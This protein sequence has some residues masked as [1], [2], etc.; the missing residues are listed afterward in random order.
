[1][2]CAGPAARTHLAGAAER[3]RTRDGGSRAA[4]TAGGGVPAQRGH[5]TAVGAAGARRP[6]GP[7]HRRLPPREPPRPDTRCGRWNGCTAWSAAPRAT[8][9]CC[10]CGRPGRRRRFPAALV[11][12]LPQRGLGG[13]LP[14]WDAQVAW[15]RERGAAAHLDGACLWEAAAGY[16]RTLAE[17]AALF[18]T[19]NVSFYKGLGAL[20]G[21]CLAGPADVVAEVREWRQRMG[22]T[23]FGLWPG[24]ASALSCLR[25]RL[26][27]MP[28]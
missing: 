19:T 1:M 17:V 13:Q 16:G 21:C 10:C 26:P 27:L 5:R 3:G 24:A 12:E 2:P 18:D 22:G 25:R 15:A 11:V 9:T 14:P 20:P 6:S 28:A 4:R 8:G 7:A 23:L